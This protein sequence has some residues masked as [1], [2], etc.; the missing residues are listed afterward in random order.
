MGYRQQR[1][2]SEKR[3][4]RVSHRGKILETTGIGR[5]HIANNSEK[6]MVRNLE[7]DSKLQTHC[8]KYHAP[9]EAK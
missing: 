7:N 5:W 8:D 1:A 2:S 4:M 6:E 3:T 9:A